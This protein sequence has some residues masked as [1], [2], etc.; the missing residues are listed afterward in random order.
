MPRWRFPAPS[1]EQDRR[2]ILATIDSWWRAFGER[3]TTIDAHFKREADLDLPAFMAESLQAIDDNLM[4]EYGPAIHHEGHRLV[5]TPES[6]RH[7]RPLVQVILGRAPRLPR[8][9]FYAYRLPGDAEDVLMTV[10]GRTGIDFAG[11][12]VRVFKGEDSR[13]NLEFH[14]PVCRHPEDDGADGASFVA[15]ETLVGEEILDHWIGTITTVPLRKPGWGARLMGA[16]ENPTLL[17]LDRVKASVDDAIAAALARLPSLPRYLADR[18]GPNAQWTS[19]TLKPPDLDD[20]PGR[21]DL[22]V[23]ISGHREL[24]QEAHG[25][26]I[27]TSRRHTRFDETFCYLKIDGSGGLNDAK[28]PDREAIENAID[29]KLR[30]AELG[31]TIGGGTGRRYSYVDLALTDVD[32]SLP[33][34]KRVL[35]G[36]DIPNRTWLLFFDDDLSDEWVG[37][38]DDTPPPPTEP[39]S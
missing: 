27:F 18:E 38:W 32:A 1:E 24:W 9:E 26:G 19:F 35:R 4:W 3:A 20:Y 2:E 23:A 25:R 30:P 34:L 11:T 36:G 14:S 7:L 33:I 15:A 29:A 12:Q 22:Y 8:W 37:I 13:V 39:P 5:I 6:R 28:F 21:S 17:P 31:G 16:K 10:Q